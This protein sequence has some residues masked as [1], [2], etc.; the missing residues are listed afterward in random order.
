MA[1]SQQTAGAEVS[2]VGKFGIV[3][4]INTLIDFAI[5]N[6][7]GKFAGWPPIPSNIVSTST[8]MIFSFFANKK[9]VFKSDSGSMLKQAGIF[10]I[11]TAFGLYVIQTGII[12]L[13]VH[14]WTAPMELV[15]KIVRGVGIHF[16]KD[17]FYVN[18]GAK[19]VAT[20]ASLTWNYILYKKVVF[21]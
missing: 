9:L 6:A 2:R 12:W 3:G 8:A 17:D 10:L 1:K 14:Q 11:T 19:A 15:V 21:K 5:F 7:L 4:I 20:V 18:N 16:F 13:L